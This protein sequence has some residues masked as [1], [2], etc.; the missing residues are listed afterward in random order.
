[1]VGTTAEASLITVARG[2]F[3]G[4]RPAELHSLLF[5]SWPAPARLSKRALRTLEDTLAKGSVTWLVKQGAWRDRLWEQ[6]APPT[7]RFDADAMRVLSWLLE[8]ALNEDTPSPLRLDAAGTLGCELMLL[9]ALNAVVGT[10][11]ELAVASQA[12]VRASPLCRVVFP[13]P[14]ALAGAPAGVAPFTFSEEQDFV[15]AALQPFLAKS[16]RQAVRYVGRLLLPVD[17]ERSGRAQAATLELLFAWADGKGRRERTGF[18]LDALAPLLHERTTTADFVA[19]LDPKLALK[20][21]HAARRAAGA[22]LFAV[23]RLE[24]WDEQDRLV[25][26]VDDG[27]EAAQARV[28][29]TELAFGRQRFAI[30]RKLRDDLVAMAP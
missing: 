7:L 5:A 13:V 25:R 8:S 1:M 19:E 20:D 10:P 28:K 29:A 11:A 3:G 18:V 2:L 14:L 9:T 27:Y 16:W 21:R 22:T 23:E 26:F 30:A 4:A 6:R 12:A 24:A 15:L 17:I